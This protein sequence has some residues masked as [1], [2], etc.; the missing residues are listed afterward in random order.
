MKNKLSL[1]TV[2]TV[3]ALSAMACQLGG[4]VIPSVVAPDSVISTPVSPVSQ[5]SGNNA[6]AEQNATVALYEQ[7][8]PGVV[9]IKVTTASGGG[10]GSGFVYDNAGHIVT[11]YHVVDGATQVEV[12]FNNGYK[13]YGTVVGTDLDSDLAVI[14]VDAPADELH[15]LNLGDSEQ[16]KVG[17]FVAALGNP[18]GL[19]SSM[20]TGIVSALGRTLDSMHTAAGST[21][22]FSAGAI[23][24]TDAAINPGNSGGPLFNINGEI[25]GVNRAIRTDT[26]TTQGE[27]LNSGIGF[28]ISSN[29]IKRVVPVLIEKGKYD[30]PYL[31]M[32]SIDDLPLAE[33]QSLKLPEMSGAYVTN[34]IPGGPA[35]KAGLKAGTT[36]TDVQDLN[37]GGDLIVAID[38]HEIKNFDQMLAYL[39]TNKG[40]GD[41]VVLTIYRDGNKMDVT[42][43]LGAR[44]K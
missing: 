20:T 29:L 9:A 7:V 21:N 17:Q 41:Q 43:T 37:A 22:P 3:L 23:I 11:N 42:V 10:L 14:K 4:S 38:G 30:Y 40:P 2:V 16:V 31:G 8:S 27:P 13:T 25:I 6:L 1:L 19:E 35:D 34:V 24:Q 15:P 32:S 28:A 12:D 18:F 44:P 36:K 33:I 5:L 26:Y 39:V